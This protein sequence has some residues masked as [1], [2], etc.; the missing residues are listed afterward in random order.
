MAGVVAEFVV[1]S[2]EVLDEGVSVDDDAGGAVGLEAA[3]RL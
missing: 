3:H 1:V 2:A